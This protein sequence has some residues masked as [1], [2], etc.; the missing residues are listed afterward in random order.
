MT[1]ARRLK[2]K[3]A[4]G[5]WTA[6][7]MLTNHV[8]LD[9]VEIAHR[10]GLDYLVVDMEHGPADSELV[11]EVC[12]TGRRMD[13]P[14]LIRPRTNDYAT[15]R[16]VTDLG[17]CGLLLAAIETSDQLDVVQTAI[18]LPPRGRRRPGGL[19]NRWVSRYDQATWQRQVEDDFIV[20][21]Q[22]ET[23]SGLEHAKAIVCHPV[24]TALAVG[25][26]DL[27]AALGVCGDMQSPILREAV[28]R[29]KQTATAAQKAL[30]MMGGDPSRLAQDGYHFVC[31]GEA[32]A[33]LESA[34]RG[35]SRPPSQAP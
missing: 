8:W 27:S 16:Y 9:A 28:S 21:P 2:E 4:R 10:A 15:L 13:F 18:Y 31:L 22:V 30:W 20:L 26:Y 29:L 35:L 23:R 11:G 14:V 25:P 5:E 17:P 19:G 12:S 1:P 32:M 34:F 6:G 33:I 7:V 24:T 3:I